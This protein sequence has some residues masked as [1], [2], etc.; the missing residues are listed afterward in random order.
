MTSTVK[1]DDDSFGYAMSTNGT[2]PNTAFLQQL[3]IIT[4]GSGNGFRD[5]DEIDMLR[6]VLR[7]KLQEQTTAAGLAD[8]NNVWICV[9]MVLDRFPTTGTS[10]ADI[11]TPN[12]NVTSNQ[13]KY[14]QTSMA[15]IVNSARFRILG[16]SSA[17]V[18]SGYKFDVGAVNST[19]VG[20][21][22]GMLVMP[23]R[24]KVIYD[25][26]GGGGPPNIETNALYAL[27]TI[28]GTNEGVGH[29]YYFSAQG[30]G[31]YID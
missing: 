17:Y 14:D 12:N 13:G 21:A 15:N 11:L 3:A 19:S 26:T 24:Y 7:W 30:R 27:V 8:G 6:Y 23:G 18:Q 25:G 9:Y 1:W 22:H 16:K 4:L 5:N 28:S 2:I 10:V 20:T 29:A 31:F